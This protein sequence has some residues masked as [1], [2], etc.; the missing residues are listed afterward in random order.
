MTIFNMT[1][2]YLNSSKSIFTATE[3]HQQPEVYPKTIKLVKEMKNELE[4]FIGEI[5]NQ[6]DFDIILAGAG[7]SEFVGNSLFS[8]LNNKYDNKVKSYA[9]TDIVATPKNYINAT[10]PTILVNYGRSGNSPESVGS[11]SLATKVNPNIKHLFITCNKD[12]ALSTYAKNHN[13]ALAINLPDETHDKSFAMT[14]SYTN[15]LLACLLSFNLDSLDKFEEQMQYIIKGATKLVNEDFGFFKDLV[16]GYNF[17]RI[18]YLGA[19]SLKGMAQESALKMLEL[20][21]GGCVTMFDTPLGFRHGPKSI[22]NDETLTVVYLSDNEYTQ[23]YEADLIKEMSVQRKGNKILLISA[24]ENPQLNELV[25]YN[26][27]F[28]NEVKL[29]NVLLSLEYIIVA[30]LIALNN[31]LK[32]DITP[33][34]PCPTGEVNRVVQGVTIYENLEVA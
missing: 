16:D 29:D 3:I 23:Q 6:E 22:I 11:V 27:C 26:Y 7:T 13:N 17:N 2:E 24:T 31:S 18:V 15:M 8:F 4:E 33:D 32:A 9:T 21:A 12:G 30:Q 5:T 34:N 19:N 10:K 14:S 25:D 20:T 1:N 28:N